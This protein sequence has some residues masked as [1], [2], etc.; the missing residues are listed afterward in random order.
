MTNIAFIGLGHMGWPMALNLVNAGFKVKA[1]DIN[2]NAVQQLSNKGA[3]G[4]SSLA[5][6]AGCDIYITMLQNGSQVKHVCLEDKEALMNSA[7]QE[8]LF[9]DCSTIDVDTSRLLHK[10]AAERGFLSLDAPVSG[11]VAAATAGNL[12]IMIGGNEIALAKAKNVFKAIGDKL[13]LTGSE[14]TGQAAIPQPIGLA[15]QDP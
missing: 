2:Q 6:L 8:A 9:I 10:E 1:Y 4:C 7:A 15:G 11:G 13:I 3:I 14:G 5:E 12:T